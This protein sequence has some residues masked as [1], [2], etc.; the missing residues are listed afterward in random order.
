MRLVGE[1][2]GYPADDALY[3]ACRGVRSRLAAVVVLWLRRRLA[4][5]REEVRRQLRGKLAA[6]ATATAAAVG[7]AVAT[8]MTGRQQPRDHLPS[9]STHSSTAV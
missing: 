5:G 4:S 1:H 8:A 3:A 6:E 7:L 2:A 9:Q